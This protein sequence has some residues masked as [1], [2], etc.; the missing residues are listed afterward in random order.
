MAYTYKDFARETLKA[1]NQILT[2]KE[3]WEQ[4]VFRDFH[5]KLKNIGKTPEATI[6][7]QLYLDIKKKGKNSEFIQIDKGKF[8]LNPLYNNNK[9][10]FKDFAIEVLTELNNEP[11]HINDIWA[12][13]VNKGYDKKLNTK[14][15]NPI[16]TL[17]T[18]IYED[19]KNNGDNSEFVKVDEAKFKLRYFN[20]DNKQAEFHIIEKKKFDEKDMYMPFIE[21]LKVKFNVY[22]KRIQESNGKKGILNG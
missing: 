4:G 21:Y 19:I 11:T 6:S 22:G 12:Y 3:I 15:K 16:D 7:A 1:S 18:P 13:G 10:T 2:A 17:S 8:S 9:Y 5:K 14:S 20:N